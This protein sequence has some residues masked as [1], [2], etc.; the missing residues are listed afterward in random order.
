MESSYPEREINVEIHMNSSDL[1]YTRTSINICY[2]SD[3]GAYKPMYLLM[4]MIIQ[5]KR[6]S[7]EYRFGNYT[8]NQFL[9]D[10][11]IHVFIGFYFM[12]Y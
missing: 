5:K 7:E 6:Q 11:S 2:R 3:F 4:H 12:L 8:G 10:S 1:G 9:I